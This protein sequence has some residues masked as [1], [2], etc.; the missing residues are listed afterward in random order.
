MRV[1]TR[2][3]RKLCEDVSLPE[4]LVDR[5]IDELTELVLRTATRTT[6]KNQN[7]IRAWMFSKDIAKP[8]LLDVLRL[9]E[10]SDLM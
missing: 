9:E 1:T 7:R 8:N 4:E 5:H 3:V 2:A 6:N 10:D